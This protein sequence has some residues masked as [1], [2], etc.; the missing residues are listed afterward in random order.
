MVARVVLTMVLDS[1]KRPIAHVSVSVHEQLQV[2]IHRN[3]LKLLLGTHQGR[4]MTGRRA[5]QSNSRNEDFL[6]DLEC[7][8]D[9]GRAFMR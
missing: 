4:D 9:L 6:F 5:H 2:A 7:D 1:F 8:F 3:V